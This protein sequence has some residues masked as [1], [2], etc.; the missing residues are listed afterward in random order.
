MGGMK[1]DLK[2]LAQMVATLNINDQNIQNKGEKRTGPKPP[3]PWRT[4]T[5]IAD[6]RNRKLCLRCEKPGHFYRFCKVF[7]PPKV[8][9]NSIGV[10]GIDAGKE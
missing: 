4:E 9:N 1:V 5:E 8:P 6:L 10:N 7:G 2:S 3:A